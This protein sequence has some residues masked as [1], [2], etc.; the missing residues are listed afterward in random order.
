MVGGSR[1]QRVSLKREAE[2]ASVGIPGVVVGEDKGF[3]LLVEVSQH[4]CTLAPVLLQGHRVSQ[5][6]DVLDRVEG[7]DGVGSGASS[8]GHSQLADGVASKP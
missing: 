7:V 3:D 4:Q 5:L 2:L 6:L 1:Q 8:R